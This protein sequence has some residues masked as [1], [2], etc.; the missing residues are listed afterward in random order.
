MLDY[1]IGLKGKVQGEGLIYIKITS[2][3]KYLLLAFKR[4]R[5]NEFTTDKD[6]SCVVYSTI[7]PIQGHEYK[8]IGQICHIGTYQVGSYL[9]YVLMGEKWYIA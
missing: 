9:A 1:Y 6:N 4:F 3:P 2:F 7:L 5:C 8:L